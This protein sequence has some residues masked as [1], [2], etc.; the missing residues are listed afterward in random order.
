[1][2]AAHW[3]PMLYGFNVRYSTMHTYVHTYSTYIQVKQPCVMLCS[4]I[5]GTQFH[6]CIRTYIHTY[7]III[8]TYVCTMYVN[9]RSCITIL[10]WYTYV[11]VGMYFVRICIFSTSIPHIQLYWF[12]I[13]FG[14]CKENGK[15]KAYGAGLLSSFGELQV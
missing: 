7:N 10:I 2:I 9:I 4:Y 8:P 5:H 13:E 1:M 3:C 11:H 12:T 15:T 6:P 14:L